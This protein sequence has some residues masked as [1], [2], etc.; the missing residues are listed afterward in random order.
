MINGRYPYT[1]LA[2]WRPIS[3]VMAGRTD[4]KSAFFLLSESCINSIGRIYMDLFPKAV[5]MKE[6]RCTIYPSTLDFSVPMR[7][8]LNEVCTQLF[9]HFVNIS[10]KPA[11]LENRVEE[12]SR[13][14]AIHGVQILN[15]HWQTTEA[16]SG[17]TLLQFANCIGAL[18]AV[19][20]FKWAYK[21]G[22]DINGITERK[23][24]LLEGAFHIKKTTTLRASIFTASQTKKNVD[25]DTALYMRSCGG[26]MYPL[27]SH[28]DVKPQIILKKIDIILFEKP[29]CILTGHYDEHS[30]FSHLP[31]EIVMSVGNLFI[32]C[33]RDGIER[34]SS[35]SG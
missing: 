27:L 7:K 13:I 31:K 4:K 29:I 12:I 11:E 34:S 21:L 35:N 23:A 9:K 19:T 25:F 17:A 28:D 30:I 3:A 6:A 26:I 32:D 20:S 16:A 10:L 18:R 22:V 1:L 15:L 24:C 33:M 8:S 5:F 2:Q 14:L